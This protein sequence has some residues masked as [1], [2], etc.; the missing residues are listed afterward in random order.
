MF[1]IQTFPLSHSLSFNPNYLG[2]E[3]RVALGKRDQSK[4]LRLVAN[5]LQI[6]KT[7]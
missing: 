3:D 5:G 4:M 1:S 6:T 7:G 2:D